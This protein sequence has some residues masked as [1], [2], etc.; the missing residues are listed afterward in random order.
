MDIVSFRPLTGGN[1]SVTGYLHRPMESPGRADR[2]PAI[3]VCPGGG[4]RFLSLR[5]ADP[6]AMAY[7]AAGYQVFLLSYSTG[8]QAR[9]LQPLGEL[10]GT[11]AALRDRAT[12]WRLDPER[13]YLCGFS[14]GGH[15]AASLGVLW[16]HPRLEEATGIPAGRNRPCGMILGYPVILAGAYAHIGSIRMVS[17]HEPGT[18]ESAFFS[19]ERHVGPDT[20]PA[21]LWHTV[22]DEKVPVEN[23]LAM[24]RALQTAGISYECHIFPHGLHGL[25][26]C[27]RETGMENPAA[28][29]WFPM[30]LTWLSGL[31][32]EKP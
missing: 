18:P 2:W 14:A 22:E 9:N 8:P 25:S 28:A 16:R 15:L 20:C 6:V 17:G 1:A 23:T 31:S 29:Q 4:Y 26:M 12:E 13:I 21:F 7:F 3:V 30:S 27:T 32:P 5:E 11:V 19:L 24:V 10:S